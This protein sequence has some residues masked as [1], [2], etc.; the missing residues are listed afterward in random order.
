MGFPI[1]YQSQSETIILKY[2]KIQ[3]IYENQTGKQCALEN[4]T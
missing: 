1:L 3:E 2:N 4:E